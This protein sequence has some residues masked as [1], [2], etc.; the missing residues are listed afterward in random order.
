MAYL[1]HLTAGGTTYDIAD[2]EVRDLYLADGTGAHN[3]VYGGRYL[4]DSVTD[5]QYEAISDGTF[6]DLY[7]GDY[8][9]ID[10]VN[11]RIAHF[12]Y[13]Y[14]TGDTNCTTNH[15][16]IVPDTCLLTSQQMN[17]SA[18]TEGGYVGSA[19]YTDVLPEALE[20]VESA[21]GSDH[22]LTHR[23]WLISAV[24][25]GYSSTGAWYD[26]QI[27]LMNE[28]MVYGGFVF[29]AMSDGSTI[30]KQYRVSKSQLQ[31]FKFRHDLIGVRV[32]YWLRDVVSSATF[33]HVHGNGNASYGN[34]SGSYGVRPAFSII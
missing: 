17:S 26:S 30:P 13:Y 4:G 9:T 1:K 8:W 23:L 21:F 27:E 11:Y 7:I 28:Q 3:A 25:S 18:T 31:L 22:I 32:T 15:V 20:I 10:D 16:T 6:T 19:M 14:N 12:N 2:S 24:T 34:A 33:A 5:E 29:A